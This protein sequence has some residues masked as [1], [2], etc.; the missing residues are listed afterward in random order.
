M[1]SL[2]HAGI[3][4]RHVGLQDLDA[5]QQEALVEHLTQQEARALFDLQRGP[6]IRAVVLHLREE[7]HILCLSMHHIVSD[8]WSNEILLLQCA[9]SYTAY[10]AGEP[11]PLPDLPIQYADYALW[12]RRWLVGQV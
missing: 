5:A 7:E 4:L 12:Q 11:S 8:G 2:P 9:S 3:G 6:L 10:A 1:R